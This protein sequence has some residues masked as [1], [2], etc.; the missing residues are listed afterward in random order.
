M[1]FILPFSELVVKNIVLKSRTFFPDPLMARASINPAM[2]PEI[3]KTAIAFP[4]GLR[5]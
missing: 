4:N 3:E 2:I 1:R 5:S